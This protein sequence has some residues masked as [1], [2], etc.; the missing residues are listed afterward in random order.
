MLQIDNFSGK[1]I[2]RDVVDMIQAQQ[3]LNIGGFE[4]TFS[5]AP[6]K[7]NFRNTKMLQMGKLLMS[8]DSYCLSD[9]KALK[10]DILIS[11]PVIRNG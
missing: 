1:S 8:F 2:R 3:A 5:Y 11:K 6:R 7:L 10:D 4:H 9:A